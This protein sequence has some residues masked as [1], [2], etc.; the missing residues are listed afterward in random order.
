MDSEVLRYDR[1]G[2]AVMTWRDTAV[3]TAFAAVV[4][5]V[6]FAVMTVTR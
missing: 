4:V 3:V 1:M 2:G 6:L 5:A